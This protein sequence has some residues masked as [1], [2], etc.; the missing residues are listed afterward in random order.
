[1]NK[2]PVPIL[3]VTGFLGAGKTTFI[4]WLIHAV[5]EKK[6]SLILNEFGDIKLESNFIQK[7]GIG[8]VTE[9]A[10]GCMC[11]V[12]KSDI[13]RVIKYTVE[14]APMTETILIEASGLSDPDPVR[15]VLQSEDLA[16]LIRLDT[17]VCIVDG[18][19]FETQAKD[20][21][22]VIS[23]IGDADLIVL[24]KID[25]LP[26][27]K[28]DE[29][30]LTIGNIGMGTKIIPWND[31]M[32]ASYF[33]D[34]NLTQIK[35]KG[36]EVNTHEHEHIDEYWYTSDHEMDLTKLQSF[37]SSLPRT[38]IR[39][40][41]YT[42]SKDQQILIQYVGRKFELSAGAGDSPVI[43]AILFL[44]NNID[45]VGMESVLNACQTN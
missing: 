9:L 10:N 33:F 22:I 17:I 37:F 24:S 16:P 30:I 15:D 19:N 21:P 27:E 42:K 29:L 41:G 45:V 3:L 38:I 31:S 11:C 8:L 4:N 43:T 2:R 44:G 6:V 35:P 34:T 23:Q 18:E 25:K 32:K 28:I 7:E 14:N 13:P 5:P 1:M 40:K 12:A 20:H 26:Q 39:A 36:S